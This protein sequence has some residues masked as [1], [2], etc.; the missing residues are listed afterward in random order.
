MAEQNQV[1]TTASNAES[2]KNEPLLHAN[3]IVELVQVNEYLGMLRNGHATDI[4]R[5]V[6]KLKSVEGKI[7]KK[8]DEISSLKG[9]VEKLRNEL[10]FEKANLLGDLLV[11]ER[12]VKQLE[13]EL[14]DSKTFITRHVLPANDTIS[15][16]IRSRFGDGN[17][18][19]TLNALPVFP[20]IR[21]APEK[22][23]ISLD[24]SNAIEDIS[25]SSTV[26]MVPA[27]D[28]EP[29]ASEVALPADVPTASEE[30]AQPVENGDDVVGV[31]AE[32]ENDQMEIDENAVRFPCGHCPKTYNTMARKFRHEM[33]SHGNVHDIDQEEE[34]G[35]EHSP[36][37]LKKVGA[38]KKVAAKNRI[39]KEKK[40]QNKMMENILNAYGM[41]RAAKYA[42]LM[43]QL[44]RRQLAMKPAFK[45]R[46]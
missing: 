44:R 1:A 25:A 18:I 28:P 29:A 35:A 38:A 10:A 7:H 3:G 37:L 43:Q 41:E 2:A 24:L 22:S 40:K 5:F 19:K 46:M 20:V 45:N 17:E 12:K 31:E 39:Q 32:A 30:E 6:R 33:K 23:G 21:S 26:L 13:M 16:L 8:D 42:P 15:K 36:K 34:N 27:G 14:N 11:A 9:E 4:K